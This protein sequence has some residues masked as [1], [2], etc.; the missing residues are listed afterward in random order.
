MYVTA[1]SG[2]LEV[3]VYFMKAKQGYTVKKNVKR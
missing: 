2:H 1:G 3:P